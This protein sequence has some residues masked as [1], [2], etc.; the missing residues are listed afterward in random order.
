MKYFIVLTISFI[1][2]SIFGQSPKRA[3]KKL[4]SDP[5]FFI[6][7]VSVEKRDLSNY[8]P[9]E[10]ASVSVYKD[11]NAVNLV[12]PEGKDGV[13]YITTIKFAKRKY[14]NYFKSKSTD[15]EKLI[16]TPESDTAVQYILNK[17][18]LKS[19]FE[20]DLFLIDDKIFK[21]LK[22][23]D[24]ST[25]EKEYGIIDKDYG[26]LIES[27]RPPDLYKAKKKF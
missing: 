26:V 6:D 4:G 2:V 9:T 17:R 10:I 22:I 19:N 1:S 7:S 13:V 15:Y 20:G 8:Q 16:L 25:L 12:G 18:I 3:I 11:S 24:K 5:V 27:D 14:W 23:L 21:G